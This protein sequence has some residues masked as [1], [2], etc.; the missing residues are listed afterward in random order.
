M[1]WF[2]SL[3][4]RLKYR[5]ATLAW[6]ALGRLSLL[7]SIALSLPGCASFGPSSVDRDRFDY[8]NAI[9]SSWKQQT[10]LNIVKMRYADTPVFLEVGQIISGYQLQGAVTVSGTL[11][12]AS[13][14]GDIVNLGSAA[15]YTDRPT[16][17]YT[18]LTGAHFIQV[19]MTPI[20][21]PA[22]FRLIEQG[23]PVDMLLQVGVQSINGIS[24]HK[25]GA[26]GSAMD[27]D[28]AA[29]L[30][31][32]QRLQA[33][34][35]LGL[36]VEVSPETKQEGTVMVISRKDL[37]PEVEAD[38]KLV[39][40]LLGL[41]TDVQEFKVVYGSVPEKDDVVAV[42]TR[43]GLQILNLLGSTVEVPPEHIAELRTYPTF[44]ES[45][46]ARSLPPL[47]RVHADNLLPD[48]AFAAVKYRDYWYW[49]DDRDFRS[50]G[51]FSFLMIIMTLAEKGEKV[52]PPV[53]TIQGN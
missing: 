33:S 49:I 22:L 50:K 15:T 41:R 37:P 20:P 52:Q 5:E 11:N 53:V 35:A 32:F 29:L 9:A 21:P 42:Q 10:L 25:G 12:S 28:F 31:A 6:T 1:A 40:K 48:N 46:G 45:E 36:R 8:I 43:S 4:K 2:D 7:A 30:A 34:G 19:L 47:I 16:I 39:R 14:V 26:R 13:A 44:Q 3:L 27:P 23:W 24:N 38:R 18:P 51:V 17:T